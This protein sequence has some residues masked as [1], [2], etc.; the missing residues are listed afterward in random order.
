MRRGTG[1]TESEALCGSV[2]GELERLFPQLKVQVT[3]STEWYT[4]RFESRGDWE[5]WVWETVN[6]KD[7]TTRKPFFSGY[8]VCIDPMGRANAEI[9]KL[10]LRNGKAVFAWSAQSPIRSVQEVVTL[11]GNRWVDGWSVRSNPIQ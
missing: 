1:K 9:T 5:S 11:D 10:A 3:P 6:G 8:A 2:S 4:E 7:Y